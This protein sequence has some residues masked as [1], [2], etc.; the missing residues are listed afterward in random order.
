MIETQKAI[1]LLEN[2]NSFITDIINLANLLI[3]SDETS[4]DKRIKEKYEEYKLI[5]NFFIDYKG[6]QGEYEAEDDNDSF[7]KLEKE[8]WDEIENEK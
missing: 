2:K 4:N 6:D 7:D 1:S 5:K 3:K 8:L